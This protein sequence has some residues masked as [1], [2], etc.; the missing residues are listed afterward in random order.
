LKNPKLN[1]DRNLKEALAWGKAVLNSVGI[2]PADREARWLLEF[3]LGNN[4]L[5]TEPD[6]M[7]TENQRKKYEDLISKRAER[8]PLQYLIGE[9]EFAGAVIEVTPDV[10]IPRPET[11]LLVEYVLEFIK[12]K[13]EPVKCADLGTGSGCI[14]VA[15]ATEI[16]N[17]KFEIRNKPTRHSP[18]ANANSKSNKIPL[19]PFRKGGINP[20]SQIQNPKFAWFVCDKSEKAL[21]LARKN[22]KKNGVDDKISF[23]LGSWFD[24]FPE[25]L[26]FD[27]IVSNP[28]YV[29]LEEKLEPE[30]AQEPSMALFS[31]K[32][33]LDDYREIIAS[34]KSRLLPGGV[35]IGE[36]S[37]EQEQ[38]LY[39]IARQ[40]ELTEIKFLP[41][42]TGRKRF[43]II[44]N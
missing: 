38:E 26:K 18:G 1:T 20:K 40:N 37:P 30:L 36:F 6:S 19:A 44:K 3:V 8:Y 39:N 29:R 5:I 17:S 25:N 43:F 21:E 9:I 22:A 27:L 24:A 32:D 7:L 16:R 13:K 15:V 42:L 10:L 41:D 34:L 14:A 11:E 31:G 23:Y 12:D 28:P 2:Y 35:F 33:G 4:K